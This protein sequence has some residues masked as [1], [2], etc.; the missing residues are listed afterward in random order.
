MCLTRSRKKTAQ[1]SPFYTDQRAR[2]S[3]SARDYPRHTIK[4]AR[5]I[6]TAI[7]AQV[8]VLN[9]GSPAWR[10]LGKIP[11]HRI[12]QGPSQVL[13]CGRIHCYTWPGCRSDCPIII[14]FDFEDEQFREVPKPDCGGLDGPNSHLVDLRGFLSAAVYNSNSEFNIWIMKEYDVKES[15]IKEF[16]IGNHVPRSLEEDGWISVE[17]FLNSKLNRNSYKSRVVGLLKNGKVLLE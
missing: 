4:A 6:F 5:D 13:V 16:N 14:S 8:Q 7:Q 2:W 11:Y 15:W 1:I 12:D 17:P 3:A 10:N 9:L